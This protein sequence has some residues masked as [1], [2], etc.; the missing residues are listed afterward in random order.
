MKAIIIGFCVACSMILGMQQ[1]LQAQAV[2]EGNVIVEGFYGWPN[3]T[4]FLLRTAYNLSASDEDVSI[5]GSGPFGARAEYIIMENVGI[6]IDAYYGA[7]GIAWKSNQI[8]PMGTDTVYDYSVDYKRFSL[9][10]RAAYHLN[11]SDNFDAYLSGSL[12]YRYRRST[13]DTD[14]PFFTPVEVGSL[15]P[16]S[17]RGAIGGRY[18]ISGI[19]GIG[20]ELALGGPLISG[21]IS[22]KI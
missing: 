9:N 22:V 20:M 7:S 11:V 21:G 16:I 19:V 14:D 15:I 4:T 17:V 8:T 18:Y 3:F 12:G 2:E 5:T 13:I 6:G 10:V 1:N